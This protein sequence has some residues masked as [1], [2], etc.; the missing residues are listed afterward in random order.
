M[1]TILA[2]ALGQD[3]NKLAAQEKR[4]LPSRLLARFAHVLDQPLFS[5]DTR[6]NKPRFKL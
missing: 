1:E 5:L 6:S 2:T 3:V 4:W